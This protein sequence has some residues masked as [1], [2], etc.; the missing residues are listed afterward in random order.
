MWYRFLRYFLK[1]LIK[2]GFLVAELP[3]GSVAQ[4]GTVGTRPVKIRIHTE[5]SLKR[6]CTNPDLALGECY[7]S[8]ELT[9]ENDDLKSLLELV[10]VNISAPHNVFSRRLALAL[11]VLLRRATQFNPIARARRNVK[12][13]YDLSDELYKLF[14]DDDLQYSCAYF[15]SPDDDLATAQAQKKAHIARKLL[16]EPGMNILDIGSGW[17]GLG[18]TLARDYGCNVKGVTLAT[19]QHRISNQRAVAEGLTDQAKFLL[20][21]YRKV[22]EKFDRI[23]SVGMF[24][25]VGAPHYRKFFRKLSELLEDDG[26]ALLHTI[27]RTGPPG[28]TNP[29]ITKYIFP[30]GYVPALSETMAAIERVGLCVTDVEVLRL[31]YAETLA[32]WYER[33]MSNIGRVQEIYDDRF[34]RMWRFY[35]VASEMTFRHGRQ[36]VFQIQI[37][38]KPGAVPLTRDYNYL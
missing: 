38:K 29:W 17:G 6:L 5:K 1:N 28:A 12:H 3:D 13:H 9:V 26:V 23:V 33:F 18:L 37:S 15:K 7:M 34:C 8:G 25:H 24:E 31:H 14:L 2:T 35:L 4:A 27:G 21:D 19:N 32:Y 10:M 20:L 36:V 30:G 22:D 11:R 16:L